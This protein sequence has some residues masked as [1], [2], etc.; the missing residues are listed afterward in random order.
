VQKVDHI[1][2]LPVSAVRKEDV[3]ELF[4]A[5]FAGFLRQLT[6]PLFAKLKISLYSCLH[7]SSTLLI[8]KKLLQAV[9]PGNFKIKP[10][11]DFL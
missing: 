2:Y 3:H 7:F 8:V 9:F 11:S 1:N 5:N 6:S 4:P 10:F